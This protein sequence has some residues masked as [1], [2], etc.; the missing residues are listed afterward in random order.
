LAAFLLLRIGTGG[1]SC[2]K[3]NK[4][5]KQIEHGEFLEYQRVPEF[6]EELC[7]IE[8]AI[9]SLSSLQRPENVRPMLDLHVR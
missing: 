1:G 8:V 5:K 9:Q 6:T 4:P 7:C 2:E 3:V